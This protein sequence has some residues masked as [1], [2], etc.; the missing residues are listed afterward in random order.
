VSPKAPPLTDNGWLNAVPPPGG[1]LQGRVT[2]LLF[3]SPSCEASIA[4][5]REIELVLERSIALRHGLLGAVGVLS[6]RHHF[7]RSRRV[8]ADAV[9]RLGVSIPVVH[10]PDLEIWSRYRPGGWPTTIVVDHRG[11]ALG[12]QQGLDDLDVLVEAARLAVARAGCDPRRQPPAWP[13]VTPCDPVHARERSE[14]GPWAWPSGVAVL[15]DESLAIVD[16]G[17]DRV[18]IVALDRRR[19]RGCIRGIVEGVPRPGRVTSWGPSGLAVSLP[20]SGQV[21]GVDRRAPQRVELVADGLGRPQG[22]TQDRDGTLVVC[23]ATDE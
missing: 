3:W 18:V 8:A 14:T 15:P 22:L 5:L 23:D 11:R 12:A 20:D 1:D 7:E 6:P 10:D 19:R 2:V 9:D 17:H 4:R 13:T 16:S 21:V